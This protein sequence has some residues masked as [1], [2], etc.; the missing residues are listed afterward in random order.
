MIE[1][2]N[3]EKQTA[4]SQITASNDIPASMRELLCDPDP[5]L[6][7]E[8]DGMRGLYTCGVLD[9]FMK[10]GIRFPTVYG[11]SAGVCAAMSYV[12]GQAG[13][14]YRTNTEHLNNWR[15]CSFRS[16][17]FTGDLF[18]VKFC[19]DELINKL[20][21]F[22]FDS[23]D[24]SSTEL[25]AVCSNVVTGE[26]EYVPVED[27]R[28]DMIYV[29]AS[30]SMPLVS[31]IVETPIGKLLD[32][33]VCDS[34][35]IRHALENH[36]R[37]VVV[38]TQPDGFKKEPSSSQKY[39]E[40]FYRKYPKF[41]EANANRHINYNESLAALDKA[42]SDGRALVIRPKQA[43]GF[44]RIEKDEKKLRAL[45]ECGM[46]DAMESEIEGFL[47]SSHI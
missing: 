40:R 29:R 27:S 13:R 44:A 22:D 41:V 36:K 31:R 5:A 12:S 33:G 37:A 14:A 11:V 39:I 6:V 47:G 16:L 23:F 25:F 17:I 10:S 18:G 28:R 46:R 43:A 4:N 19:Y 30:S 32:G 26:A 34:I 7:R 38:L 45:Y 8:G 35:P 42:V 24:N 15:Y 3:M 21:P 1:S 9:Y 2:V 20:D